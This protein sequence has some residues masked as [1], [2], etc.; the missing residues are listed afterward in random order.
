VDNLQR[1]LVAKTR[2]SECT[3]C[4]GHLGGWGGV[5]VGGWSHGSRGWTW[6]KSPKELPSSVPRASH[7]NIACGF[8]GRFWNVQQPLTCS[9]VD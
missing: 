2:H 8:T 5:E 9:S 4:Y 6:V 1:V 3:P 7:S